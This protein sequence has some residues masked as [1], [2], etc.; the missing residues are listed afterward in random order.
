MEIRSIKKDYYATNVN[1]TGS[2]SW[3]SGENMAKFIVANPTQFEN[4]DILELGAGT[5]LT[6]ITLSKTMDQGKGVNV[7][8]LILTDGEIEIV[9]LLQSNCNRN[10]VSEATSCRQLLWGPGI[11]LDDFSVLHPSGFHVI[12]GCDLFYNRSQEDKVTSVFMTVQQLLSHSVG[13]CFYLSFTRRDLDISIV[14]SL[15][16]A[17]GFRSELH[18][19][20]IFDLF[21]N[22][23]DGPTDLWRDAIYI[24]TR[25]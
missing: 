11:S 21:G 4:R 3:F 14:L 10:S 8:K 5:G 6:G 24:F 9:G 15:A 1:L 19:D 16:L 2:C 13:S 18:N 22:N 12:F 25:V 23:T 20:Y 7:N 17:Q